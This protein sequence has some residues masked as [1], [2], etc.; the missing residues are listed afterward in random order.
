MLTVEVNDR[1]TFQIAPV[2]SYSVES[3]RLHTYWWMSQDGLN[4]QHLEFLT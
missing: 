4:K 3:H 1:S 2:E